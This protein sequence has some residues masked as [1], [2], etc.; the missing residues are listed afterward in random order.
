M[1]AQSPKTERKQKPVDMLSPYNK[2]KTIEVDRSN[3][4][5][6]QMDRKMARAKTPQQEEPLVLHGKEELRLHK[7]LPGHMQNQGTRFGAQH[8]HEITLRHL[9][10]GATEYLDPK[11][12]LKIK[13]K[14]KSEK[15]SKFFCFEVLFLV[16][17]LS[18]NEL[19]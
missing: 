5:A 10:V 16:V 4:H 14:N 8:A 19:L 2:Y 1:N 7:K 18:F 13:F 6:M 11:T 17:E 9:N 15:R 3:P 12:T